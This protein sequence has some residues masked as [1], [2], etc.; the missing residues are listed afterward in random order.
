MLLWL[1]YRANDPDGF[2]YRVYSRFL[3]ASKRRNGDWPACIVW[4]GGAIRQTT[5]VAGRKAVSL[6]LFRKCRARRNRRKTL[7]CVTGYSS[8]AHTHDVGPALQS[9]GAPPRLPKT[10]SR[11]LAFRHRC[12]QPIMPNKKHHGSPHDFLRP[13]VSP[14]TP[15]T[16]GVK[17]ISLTVLNGC[18]SRDAPAAKNMHHLTHGIE[19]KFDASTFHTTPHP[20]K[21]A[22]G[23]ARRT[24]DFCVL[25]S[26][27]MQ[28]LDNRTQMCVSVWRLRP[29][30]F[31]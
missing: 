7:P 26:T 25:P 28:R 19:E 22:S 20:A 6:D 10:R 27:F 9:R 2:G 11:R 18:F 1:E 13:G 3:R 31:R 29:G 30:N 24:I 5:L 21:T 4:V 17:A 15:E 8:S 16:N 12:K 14:H 23:A